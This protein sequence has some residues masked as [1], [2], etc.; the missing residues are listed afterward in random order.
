[1]TTE[2]GGYVELRGGLMVPVDA[3]RLA[4]AL[5]DRDL[6]LSQEGE[7]LKIKAADDGKPDLSE[8]EIAKIKQYKFH[9]LALL[10]Y[11]PPEPTSLFA[12]PFEMP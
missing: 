5:T 10:A 4:W 1:M 12:E 2:A 8:D 7:K 6:I 11:Q 9:V 3:L